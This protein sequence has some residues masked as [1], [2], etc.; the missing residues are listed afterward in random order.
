MS[1]APT[2][3]FALG[4]VLSSGCLTA[5]LLH[6]ALQAESGDGFGLGMSRSYSH[7]VV[8]PLLSAG[9]VGMVS[10]TLRWV[11]RGYSPERRRA[12]LRAT[13]RDIIGKPFAVL[14]A[15]IAVSALATFASWEAIEQVSSLGHPL[16]LSPLGTALS[17]GFVVQ[18]AAISG[19]V[20]AIL[21]AVLYAWFLTV[22]FIAEL[23]AFYFPATRS[24]DFRGITRAVPAPA[25]TLRGL[26]RSASRRGPPLLQLV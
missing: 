20:A 17:I 23:L 22:H 12:F 21:C 4:L 2:R 8:F 16:S 1:L 19:V 11:L 3:T 13:A 24:Q 14:A 26:V 9:F 5:A 25:I 10:L 15:L 7:F 18:L 6:V